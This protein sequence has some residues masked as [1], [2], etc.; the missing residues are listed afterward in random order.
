MHQRV[1][2]NHHFHKKDGQ[3]PLLLTMYTEAVPH[4]FRANRHRFLTKNKCDPP[5]SQFLSCTLPALIP[6]PDL[7]SSENH[8]WSKSTKVWASSKL[9]ENRTYESTVPKKVLE[10]I[11]KNPNRSTQ[12]NYCYDKCTRTL[13]LLEGPEV[14]WCWKK[15]PLRGVGKNEVAAS[16]IS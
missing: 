5:W 14:Q 1:T 6:T 15:V 12:Q 16:T 3:K 10:L 11:S 4:I 8:G 13:Y 2:D 7:S 9:W